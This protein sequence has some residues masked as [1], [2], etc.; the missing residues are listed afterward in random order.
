[1]PR[2]HSEEQVAEIAGSIAEFGFVIP[3]L[4]GDEVIVARQ[5]VVA[6]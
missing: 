3:V 5:P 2:T 1:M 6:V 4:A